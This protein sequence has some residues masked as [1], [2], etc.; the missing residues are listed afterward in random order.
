MPA[1]EPTFAEVD[2]AYRRARWVLIR[3]AVFLGACMVLALFLRRLF[4]LPPPLIGT[5]FIVA[6]VVFGGDI[7]KFFRLRDRR[8]QLASEPRFPS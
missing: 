4:K 7:M 6:L 1:R 8:Q 3:H 2:T 5:A